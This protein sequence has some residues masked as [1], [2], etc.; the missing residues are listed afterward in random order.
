MKTREWILGGD[1]VNEL[2][3][4]KNLGVLKNC[5]GSFSSN[6]DDSIEKTRNKAGIIY[7]SHLDHRNVNPLTYVKFWRQAC[8]LSL[9]FG[10]ALF[11]FIP[12]LL[13]KLQRCQSWFL[14]DIFY[15]PSF[16]HGPIL[17]KMLGL[18]SAASEIA[19]K[20]LLFL[21]LLICFKGLFI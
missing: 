16:T 5:I 10:A 19:I 13:L 17:L 21:G 4:Y 18:N 20:K 12:G 3:E 2:Y 14:K 11:T 9:L 15:A 7:S 1:T 8:L 6:V